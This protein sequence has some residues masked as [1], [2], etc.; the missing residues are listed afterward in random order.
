MVPLNFHV[1]KTYRKL[2]S[3]TMYFVIPF[4]IFPQL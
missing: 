3:I 2:S 4:M 1:I